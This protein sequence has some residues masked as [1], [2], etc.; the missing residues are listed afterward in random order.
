MIALS[1]FFFFIFH[2]SPFFVLSGGSAASGARSGDCSQLFLIS[3]FIFLP[4]FFSISGGSAASGARSGDCSQ[5]FLISFLIFCLFFFLYQVVALPL[6][7]DLVIALS[8]LE[9]GISRTNLAVSQ[10]LRF[11]LD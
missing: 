5:L 1:Y 2:F 4:F 3:F 7:R 8:E 9:H 10:Q 6:E 11:R